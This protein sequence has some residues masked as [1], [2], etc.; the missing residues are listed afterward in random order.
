ML[1]KSIIVCSFLFLVA[2]GGE[3]V[4]DAS[5][6]ESMKSSLERMIE[7]LSPEDKQAY[8]KAMTKIAMRVAILNPNQTPEEMAKEIGKIVD[9]KTIK[10]IIESAK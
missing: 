10:Q 5:T 8:E 2:C 4:V 7:P 3:N 9:G 1:K 6:L